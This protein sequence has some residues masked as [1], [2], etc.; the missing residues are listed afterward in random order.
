MTC[1]QSADAGRATMTL[2]VSNSLIVSSI[3]H[4]PSINAVQLGSMLTRV[5]FLV[6]VQWG[7]CRLSPSLTSS[8]PINSRNR[9]FALF[10]VSSTWSRITR[11]AT[12]AECCE[13]CWNTAL[14]SP[15]IAF[16]TRPAL[17]MH[18]QVPGF[19]ASYRT[20]LPHQASFLSHW[21]HLR[22]VLARLFATH[23]PR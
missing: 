14:V 12:L 4:G 22:L 5:G 1:L 10:N 2:E 15:T 18:R 21:L 7:Q 13:W 16:F 9:H 6:F 11:T 23:S 8:F 3:S 17:S 20:F 19:L